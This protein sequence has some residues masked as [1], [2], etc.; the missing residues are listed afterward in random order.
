MSIEEIKKNIDL[1][2]S[3][4]IELHGA[5]PAGVDWNSQESQELRFQ[6]LLKL[7]DTEYFSIN[8]LGCGFGSLF[9][10]LNNK[11][12]QFHYNGYDISQAMI[13]AAL[14]EFNQ[15]DNCEFHCGDELLQ[16]DY[17]VASGIFNVKMGYKEKEWEVYVKKTL[18]KMNETSKLGFAFNILTSYSD[19]EYMKNYLYYAN[20]MMYFDYCKTNFSRNVALLHDYNLYEFTILVRKLY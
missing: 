20:P 3:E 9:K 18:D 13:K 10:F 11:F 16:A 6:Q 2:Y 14:Q 4:K 7:I 1:Y 8:D 15:L 19:P 12:F 5:T 17:T